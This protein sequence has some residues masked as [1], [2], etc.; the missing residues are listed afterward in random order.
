MSS[1]LFKVQTRE[2]VVPVFISLSQIL[3]T[4]YDSKLAVTSVGHLT[5]QGVKIS[6]RREFGPQK[7]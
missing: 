5:G 7:L 3:P 4:V 1:F 6:V 2:L